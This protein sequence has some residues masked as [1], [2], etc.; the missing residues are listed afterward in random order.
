MYRALLRTVVAAA[1]IGSSV[2]PLAAD[3]VQ[4]STLGWMIN[5]IVSEVARAGDIAYVGGSFRTVSPSA[6]LVFHQVTFSTTSAAAVLPRLDLDGRLRAVVALP[7]GGWIIG[8]EFT[9]VGGTTR[10]RLARLQ[11]DGTLDMSF[12]VVVDGTV[13]ALAVSG[14]TLY[15]GGGFANVGG[16]SRQGL[17]AI[18]LSAG[19]LI[20]G[21]APVVAGG[22]VFDLLVDGTTLYAAGDFATVDSTARASL[23]A[24]NGTTGAVVTAFDAGA[25]G[26]VARVL[27]RGSNLFVAG[28]FSNIGG[29][30]R[31]G[32]ARL[33]ASTGAAVSA[34]D[35]QMSSDVAAMD[36]SASTL[37]LGGTFSQ[38]GGATRRNLAALDVTTG[39][40]T[41]WQSG[42]DDTV[43]A[44]AL[45][46][47]TLF[48][49]GSFEEVGASERLYIAA[50][51]TTSSHPVLSWNPALN[52][53]ADFLGVDPVGNVFV[54]GSFTG[55]GAVRRDNLAAVDLHNGDLL[56]WN[57]G[58]N[59]WVRALDVHGN[60]VYLGGD[61]TSIAGVTR[62]HIAALN[63]DTGLA[64]SWRGDTN[65]TVSGMMI[66]NDTVYFVGSFSTVSVGTTVSRGRGGAV[67]TDGVVKPWNPSADGTIESLFV[68][69]TRVYIGGS[70][71]MLGSLTRN[72]L[73][74]VDA[75][76]GS[77]LANFAPSVDDTIYRVDVQD[78]V[79]YFGGRFQ[80]VD[81]MTRAN[82]AAVRGFSGNSSPESPLL[83]AWNPGVSGPI[84]DLDAF[85]ANVYLAGGF[86]SVGGSSRPGIAMVNADPADASLGTWRPTDVSGGSISVIDT[87]HDAVLFGGL[88][89]DADNI[90]IG[91]VLYPEALL[92]GAPRPPTTPNVRLNGSRFA[93]SWARPPLGPPP[94]S[95]VIEGGS[96]PGRRDLAN[97][98][99]GSNGTSFGA[100]GLAPGTYYL[101]M[102]SAN[103]HGVSVAGDELAFTIGAT[104]CS[105]PPE[106]PLDLTSTVTGSS[107]TLQW[108]LAPESIVTGHVLGVGSRSDSTDLVVLPVGN[109]TSVTVNAPVGAFF[110]TLA[111]V[112]D[113][114]VSAASPETVIVVG[115]PVVPPTAP[116][117]LQS[118][119]AARTVTLSWAAPPVGT[120]PFTYVIEAG[121]APGQSNIA[122]VP[123]GSTSVVATVG[124]GI[125]YV[126][127]RAVG[128]GGM[129]PA[130][131]EVVVVVP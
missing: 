21:F 94:A 34:F 40:L 71:T 52:S 128:P 89:Y 106:R 127:V 114:G 16:E 123:V 54:G 109:V 113:C 12:D 87:S 41:A 20:A 53:G 110:V 98:S 44:L 17:A 4:T 42:A 65:G 111:A 1:V 101:R 79:V 23:A 24:V 99:T 19:A 56:S 126:R 30:A 22:A 118:A 64:T 32:V 70:F 119:L 13:R 82:A 5:G 63:G 49:A 7:G 58:T 112:N 122:V 10:R 37:Y 45:S 26:R 96:G 92:S 83:L 48:V 104:T 77:A 72:R 9:R 29:L 31:R 115:N 28:N 2:V 11:A 39:N 59:G 36:A 129:G 3:P 76:T 95:Y 18:D 8:G 6:N 57:P 80:S 47:T 90:S 69:G 93:M 67:G 50:L 97:F 27:K 84:Y 116:F 105:S 33:E 131:N 61:F 102:R 46:G 120:G 124:P 55:Y 103:A 75:T 25:D 107:V 14:T 35:A 68:D 125:Y 78:A 130:G 43:A 85:G 15:V 51:D 73:A 117:E 91:A 108:R 60:T 81:G 38:A 66:A 86:G 88:L 62:H 100:A 74:A 121:T